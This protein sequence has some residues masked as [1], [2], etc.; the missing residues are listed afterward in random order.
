M[1]QIPRN[2]TFILSYHQ[3]LLSDIFSITSTFVTEFRYKLE[4]VQLKLRLTANYY[5]N[6]NSFYQ[7]L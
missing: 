1:F 3:L 2:L 5:S 6:K 7:K 4:F